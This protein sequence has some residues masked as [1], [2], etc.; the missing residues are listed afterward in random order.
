MT[1]FAVNTLIQGH[2]E[3]VAQC[4]HNKQANRKYIHFFLWSRK[5]LITLQPLSV[6][7][8]LNTFGDKCM[9]I[10]TDPIYLVTVHRS[11]SSGVS[12]IEPFCTSTC[13][14]CR[15]VRWRVGGQQ[16]LSHYG[17]AKCMTGREILCLEH[18]KKTSLSTCCSN[19]CWDLWC[20]RNTVLASAF[21]LKNVVK[22]VSLYF[23]S[24]EIQCIPSVS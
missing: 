9:K 23:R 6:L 13:L 12:G 4:T 3:K 14:T 17:K 11:D 2:L 10:R 16:R 5:T 21:L 1:S 7:N 22:K 18:W 24:R 19:Q 20:T 8:V 15:P